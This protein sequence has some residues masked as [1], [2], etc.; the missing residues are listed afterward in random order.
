MAQQSTNVLEMP[1]E[2]GAQVVLTS[3]LWVLSSPA[4][5]RV[6]DAFILVGIRR[7]FPLRALFLRLSCVSR[8]RIW[9]KRPD[10][11]L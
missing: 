9:S 11:C 5:I 6:E 2:P 10:P 3:H 8:L 4:F 7:S 1:I